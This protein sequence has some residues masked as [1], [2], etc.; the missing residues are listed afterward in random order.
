MEKENLQP[1]CFECHNKK[2]KKER[3]EVPR[4]K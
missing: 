4:I 1:L 2:T 3:R